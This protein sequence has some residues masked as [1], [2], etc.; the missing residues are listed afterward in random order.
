MVCP[1][2]AGCRAGLGRST[3]A[4]NTRRPRG[5]HRDTRRHTFLDIPG[6]MLPERLQQP[7]LNEWVRLPSLVRLFESVQSF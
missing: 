1:T 4:I 5:Q 7:R 3:I 6:P 2:P